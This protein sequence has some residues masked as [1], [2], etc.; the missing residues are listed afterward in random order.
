[1]KKEYMLSLDKIKEKYPIG[2][3]QIIDGKKCIIIGYEE[4]QVS[5]CMASYP[6]IIYKNC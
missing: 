1:M 2:T 3:T 5:N 6:K 4:P